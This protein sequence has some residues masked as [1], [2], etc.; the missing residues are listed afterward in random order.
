[1]PRGN[2]DGS[3]IKKTV[4]RTI[5]GRERDVVV[6]IARVRY[7]DLEGLTRDRKKKA[8]SLTQ[9]NLFKIQLKR[10]IAEELAGGQ[11][12]EKDLFTF[13][14]LAKYAKE[15]YIL[16]AK[17]SGDVKVSGMRSTATPL[18][19]I[20]TLIK[21]FGLEE[22]TSITHARIREFRDARLVSKTID[23]TIRSLAS[24]N[25][26]MSLLRRLM[27]IAEKQ[28]WITISPFRKG[29]SLISQASEVERM[30]IIS[31]DE[32]SALLAQCTGK[33]KHLRALLIV[34]LDTALRRREQLTLAW[35][36]IDFDKGLITVRRTNAKRAQERYVPMTKRVRTELLE[37]KKHNMGGLDSLVFATTDF[38]KAWN[39]ARSGA[40]LDDCRWHDLRHSAITWMLASGINPAQVM[41][42]SGHSSSKTFLRY[43]NSDRE[44]AAEMAVSMN[45]RRASIDKKQRRKNR[46]S[47]G[48]SKSELQ[49]S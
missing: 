36:D 30:R 26:E 32:E 37:L 1:M 28:D 48:P 21:E 18:Y 12:T 44:T 6:Y 3:I 25:R 42:V 31:H 20:E 10:E 17:Y 40:K 9:A 27:N 38:K 46:G 14:D 45:A 33:R 4:R 24:V 22:L 5:N 15:N 8:V 35:R 2:K 41:R 13:A 19:M 11:E 43:V 23:G 7:K 39:G 34:A 29:D 49:G 16:P 47:K